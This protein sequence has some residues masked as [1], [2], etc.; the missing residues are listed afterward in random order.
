M[1]P[2]GDSTRVCM[3]VRNDCRTDYRVLKE[4]G[5]L[6]QAGYQVTVIGVNTYGPLE[7]EQIDGDRQGYG[8]SF[9]IVRVPVAP[10]RT[11][12]GKTINLFPRA[13]SRMAA[14]AAATGAAFYHA[15]DSDAILPAWLAARRTPGARLVYDAHEVGFYSFRQSLSGF[16]FHLPVVTWF[17][18]LLNDRLVR[19]HAAAVITVNDVL[20][21][22]QARHY[23]IARPVVVMN[24]PPRFSSTPERRG[25]LARRIGVSSDTP[26]FICQGMFSLSR[27]DGPPLENLI[28]SAALLR[29][30]VI[31]IVGNVGSRAEFAALRDLAS[32]PEQKGR[33]FILPPVLPTELLAL[34]SD[35]TLG[36]IPL[37]LPGLLRFALPNK[38]FEYAAAGLP[39]IA[40][41]LPIVRQVLDAYGY[42]LFCDFASPAG[43]AAAIEG[44][45]AD[46][47]R[48]AAMAAGARRA[49]EV[50]NW[51]NQARILLDL[52]EGLSC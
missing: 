10:A 28:R 33:V 17:W 40:S 48:Y 9:E 37:H 36:L 41:D 18:S 32:Q 43:I 23:G 35:A 14:A 6:A 3:L 52:Y 39:V 45:L 42:G 20:A 29:R 25:D 11:P 16:P 1:K 12:V 4:A 7:R 5:A 51:E 46:P 50:Y 30:G 19:R 38:L 15:H 27:G 44:V 22:L 8:G 34:T 24:C 26:I 13:I 49:A 2:E 21:D 31:V 47:D